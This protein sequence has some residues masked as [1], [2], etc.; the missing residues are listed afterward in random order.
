MMKAMSVFILVNKA[1][2]VSAEELCYV[3][4]KINKNKTLKQAITENNNRKKKKK[5]LLP[6]H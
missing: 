2:N 1:G 5:N 6:P 3:S 4:I